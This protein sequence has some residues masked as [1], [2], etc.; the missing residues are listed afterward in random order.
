MTTISSMNQFNRIAGRYNTLGTFIPI[1]EKNQESITGNARINNAIY[2]SKLFTRNTPV[3]MQL[4]NGIQSGQLKKL[5]FTFKGAEDAHIIV[6]C[7]ALIGINSQIMFREVGD[8]VLLVWTGGSWS[9]LETLNITNPTLQ[10]PWI[11]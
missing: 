11:Q 10:S 8:Q 3:V 9:V 5:T 1:T 2:H 6:E 7:P 4:G